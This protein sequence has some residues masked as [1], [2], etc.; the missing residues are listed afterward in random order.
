MS[1]R[2]KVVIDRNGKIV[3]EVLDRG[4]HLC[5]EVYKVTSAVGRQESDE[6]IGPEC[7]TQSETQGGV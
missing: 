3:T 7:D 6:T 4:N 5:S 2:T 1:M